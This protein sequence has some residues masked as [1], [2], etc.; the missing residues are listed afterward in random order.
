[1]NKTIALLTALLLACTGMTACGDKEDSGSENTNESSVLTTEESVETSPQAELAVSIFKL[2]NESEESLDFGKNNYV[3]SNVFEFADNNCGINKLIE[4]NFG[5]DIGNWIVVGYTEA[6]K[7]FIK[8][9]GYG[10]YCIG[11]VALTEE[12]NTTWLVTVHKENYYNL[13]KEEK[14]LNEC[15]EELYHHTISKNATGCSVDSLIEAYE[16]N[17]L[18]ADNKYKDKKIE[19]EGIVNSVENDINGDYYV[20]LY[21][22][23]KYD[24]ILCYFANQDELSTLNSG[25][26]ITITGTCLGDPYIY[27]KLSDCEIVYKFE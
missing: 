20:K 15:F 3:A 4:E 8:S 18:E 19:V 2:L 12:N 11:G 23:S 16:N 10:E 21:D 24:H 1:M 22:S 17:A 14:T 26:K 9:D 6:E 7:E 5:N 13:T 27:V 25:D